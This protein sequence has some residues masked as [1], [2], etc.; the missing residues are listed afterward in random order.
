MGRPRTV[1]TTLPRYASEFKDRHGKRRI[2]L[3]RSGWPTVYITAE[4]GSP[5]FTAA[6]YAWEAGGKAK[7]ADRTIPGSFDDLIE[8]FYRS[9]RFKDVK[10]QTQRIYTGELERFRKTYG[11]RSAATMTARHVSGLMAKMA[12]TP[13]AANN[14]KKR[15]GQIFDFAVETGFRKDNPARV[16]R[17]FRNTKGGYLT[18]QEEHIAAYEARW[19]VGSMQRLAFALALYTAQRKSDVHRLGPQHVKD[20]AICF[21]QVKTNKEMRVPIHPKLAAIIDATPSGHLAFVVTSYG[22]PFSRNGIGNW[23][24]AACDEAGLQ[25]YSMHGLRKACARRLAELGLSNQLIKSI[26]GHTTDSE[27][28]RYTRDA[29]Q[30][31]LAVTA[32]GNWLTPS[33]ADLANQPETTGN[34]G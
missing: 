2:R 30:A 22:K 8:R 10:P 21:T 9:A 6:Y 34:K 17:A 5:E 19:P 20:G 13:A 23:F 33:P 24:R 25:G 26:T 4:P 7:A 28:S 1:S 3:R 15:L 32:L 12:D 14:L 11:K 16:I 31:R 29:E 27:V 18:W